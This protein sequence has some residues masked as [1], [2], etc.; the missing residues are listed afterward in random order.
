MN[1]PTINVVLGLYL[2]YCHYLKISI[3]IYKII[4]HIENSF[5]DKFNHNKIYDSFLKNKINK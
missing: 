4:S 2:N 5:S 3:L 1:L